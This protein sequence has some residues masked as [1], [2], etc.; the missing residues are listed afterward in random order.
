M[1]EDN[2]SLLSNESLVPAKAV[3]KHRFVRSPMII[4]AIILICSVVG[5][6]IWGVFFNNTIE[7]TVWLLSYQTEGKEC[8]IGFQMEQGKSC[9]FYNGGVMYKGSYEALSSL[10]NKEM[11]QMNYTMY[12]EPAMKMSYY[13]RL[14]G[15]SLSG[16]KLILTDL[17]EK[18]I[19]DSTETSSQKI[20]A[21]TVEENGKTY[22]VYTLSP[23]EE[24]PVPYTALEHAKTDSKLLGIWL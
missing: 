13:Y 4:A 15:Y 16:W 12:G 2:H 17:N 21:D 18:S 10:N 14:D 1:S 24:Y 11:L 20:V 22:Y 19:L 3:T 5:L 9:R 23:A 8:S 7:N 6:T